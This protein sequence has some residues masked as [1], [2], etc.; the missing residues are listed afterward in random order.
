MTFLF[1]IYT[2]NLVYLKKTPS[3]NCN[4]MFQPYQLL[5]DILIEDSQCKQKALDYVQ[6]SYIG[7]LREQS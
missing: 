7:W 4:P 1:N 2:K 6:L 3:L 5:I